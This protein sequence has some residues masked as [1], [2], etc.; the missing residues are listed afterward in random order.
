MSGQLDGRTALIT[1]AG[2][3]IGR[4]IALALAEDGAVVALV[5]RRQDPLAETA[6][7]V[8]AA[9]GRAIILPADVS[10]PGECQRIVATLM[11]E[12]TA[13]DVVVNNAGVHTAAGPVGEDDTDAWWHDITVNLRG[14]YLVCRAALPHMGPGSTIVNVSSGAGMRGFPY[15]SAYGASK[16]ALTH[17]T[18]SLALELSA[19][20]IAV[21]AIRPGTIK[22]SITGILDTPMGRKYL[23]HVARL[24]E[25]DSEL[26]VAPER[27]ARLVVD[28]CDSKAAVLSGRMISVL[29]DLPLLIEQSERIVE[30]HLYQLRLNVL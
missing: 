27:P 28:L 11:R 21:F 29:D 5:G 14:P 16:A 24:F 2:S 22:T 17:F 4:A 10:R 18:E 7:L 26:L 25:A 8:E 3:G 9:K 15:S 13:L 19:R 1:G 12:R 20:E 23:G 30:E 6:K